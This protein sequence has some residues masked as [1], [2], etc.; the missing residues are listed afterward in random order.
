M[1]TDSSRSSKFPIVNK[2]GRDGGSGKEESGSDKVTH[3]SSYK[4]YGAGLLS[5]AGELQVSGKKYFRD[6]KINNFKHAVENYS[7][8]RQFDPDRVVQ[9]ECLITT[10]QDAYFYTRNFDEA[11]Q[12]LRFILKKFSS[13]IFYFQNLYK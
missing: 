4:I 7:K 2:E 9:Q 10:F 3:E 12:K 5:S 6:E 11:Q 8:I 1:C 13:I